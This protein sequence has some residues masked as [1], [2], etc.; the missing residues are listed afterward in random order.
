MG[1]TTAIEWCDST[2]NPV[3]GC[4][5]Y[6]RKIFVVDMGDW[7]TASVDPDDWLTPEPGIIAA[8]P[9][10]LAPTDQADRRAGQVRR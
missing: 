6:V 2:V 7:F 5:R 4:D 10:R 9:A 3:M 8:G 1:L